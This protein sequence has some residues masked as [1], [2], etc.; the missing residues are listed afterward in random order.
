MLSSAL[1]N[2]RA[3]DSRHRCLENTGELRIASYKRAIPVARLRGMLIN[4]YRW[5]V[6]EGNTQSEPSGHPG[7]T[8]GRKSF[9]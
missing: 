2:Y 1:Y 9:L 5:P 6:D 7:E 3:D 8:F 4:R